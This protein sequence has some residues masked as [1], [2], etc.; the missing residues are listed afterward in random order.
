MWARPTLIFWKLDEPSRGGVVLCPRVSF[1]N[2]R[3][4]EFFI[5]KYSQCHNPWI[6]MPVEID[7]N[8]LLNY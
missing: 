7:K 4:S 2:S 8:F 6:P 3:N 1:L 5:L